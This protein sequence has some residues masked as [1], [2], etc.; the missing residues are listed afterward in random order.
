[1][2]EKKDSFNLKEL[3]QDNYTDFDIIREK[4]MVF[5]VGDVMI[6]ISPVTVRD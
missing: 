5:K 6:I 4:P 1:M 2:F 3:L